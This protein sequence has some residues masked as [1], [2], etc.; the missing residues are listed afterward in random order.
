MPSLELLQSGELPLAAYEPVRGSRK[1]VSEK[2][3]NRPGADSAR[4][5]FE[6][7]HSL[8]QKVSAKLGY[9]RRKCGSSSAISIF[10]IVLIFAIERIVDLFNAVGWWF[11]FA[12]NLRRSTPSTLYM[13]RLAGTVL[14]EMTPSAS[15]D[16]EP[17]GLTA[18]YEL[19][20]NHYKATGARLRQSVCL[21]RRRVREHF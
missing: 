9:V 17:A 10:P 2:R 13:V 21:R 16:G 7:A 20:K 11:T 3:L 5:R 14:N 1:V 19:A 12:P 4:R 18:G 8:P 15:V 6:V